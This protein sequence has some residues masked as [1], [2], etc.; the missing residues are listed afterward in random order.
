MAKMT[1]ETE[2]AMKRLQQEEE[3]ELVLE[4]LQEYKAE[5][6]A[7]VCPILGLDDLKARMVRIEEKLDA[8]LDGMGGG[9]EK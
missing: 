3:T 9:V 4:V 7:A 6:A 2:A 8:I 1:P 5:I